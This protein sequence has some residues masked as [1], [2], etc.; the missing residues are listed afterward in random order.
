V[1]RKKLA[2]DAAK[3]E[4]VA[5]RD[6]K[7]KNQKESQ[8][9]ALEDEKTK[10]TKTKSV[11]TMDD[12]GFVTL[13]TQYIRLNEDGVQVDTVKASEKKKEDDKEN[14]KKKKSNV[15]AGSPALQNNPYAQIKHAAGIQTAQDIQGKIN[16]KKGEQR[17][18]ENNEMQKDRKKPAAPV[19]PAVPKPKKEKK[20]KKGAR[21]CR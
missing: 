5:A 2:R 4:A 8:N 18:L 20:T 15:P 21:N 1:R 7:K 17:N 13:D 6:G 3:A 14:E 9:E 19:V 11:K 10:K 12:D 16:A